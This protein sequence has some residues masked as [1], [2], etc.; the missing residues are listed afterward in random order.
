MTHALKEVKQSGNYTFRDGDR[1]A[2]AQESVYVAAAQGVTLT[3]RPQVWDAESQGE[4]R[5]S[6]L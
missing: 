6:L 3:G 5:A 1:N 2:S 4:V